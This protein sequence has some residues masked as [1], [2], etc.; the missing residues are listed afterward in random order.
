MVFADLWQKNR[1]FLKLDNFIIVTGLV[2]E[3]NYSGNYRFNVKEI[4]TLEKIRANLA[5]GLEIIIQDNTVPSKDFVAALQN[6]LRQYATLTLPSTCPVF[7]NYK[8]NNIEAKIRLSMEWAIC[9]S[10]ELIQAITQLNNDLV[11]KIIYLE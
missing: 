4:T 8:I 1:D 9:P 10:T 5:K 2:T 7:I 11:V 3:D 6:V